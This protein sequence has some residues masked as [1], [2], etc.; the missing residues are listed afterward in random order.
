M[1]TSSYVP[2]GLG[3]AARYVRRGSRVLR[4][5]ESLGFVAVFVWQVLSS[6]PL[7]LRRYRQE[8]MRAITDMTWGRGSVIVGGGTVPMMIVL[9]LVMGASVGV[10]SFAILDMLGMGPVTGIVSAFASTRELAPIAAAIGFA[11]QAGCRMTA[12]IGSMRISEEI[13]A[14]EA[15]GLRSVPFVVTTRVIAGAIA[16][17]PTFLIALIL[18]YLACRGLLTMVHSQ[19]AG[20]YDHYFFQFVSGFDVIAAVIKVAI[21]GTVV[22][23]VHSYYGFFATG[24]PEGV[25]I[26]SGR[27]VRASFVA[28]I[29]IDMVLSIALWGFNAAISFTG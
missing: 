14:I 5:V 20:V 28:I 21:F 26:A 4:G 2:K 29:A 7:T 6:V 12:E 19:S 13:D 8:T 11:A 27:A 15:L 16:I 3:W 10:E 18:S 25:G 1:S 22:I 24:G 23:L 9:G 17:V